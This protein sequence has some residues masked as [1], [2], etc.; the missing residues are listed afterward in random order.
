MRCSCTWWRACCPDADIV[1]LDTGY[2]FAETQWFAERLRERYH[3]NLR[4][5]RPRDD[6]LADQWQT[7]TDG[8]CAARKVEP[9]QRAL[10]GKSA[11]VTGLRRADSPSRAT[12]PVVHHDLLRGV[13]KVNPIATWSDAEVEHYAAM[14]LLPEHPLAGARLPRRSAAGRARAPVSEGDDARAGRWAG[15]AKTECG[16]HVDVAAAS[17]ERRGRQARER[18]PARPPG[19]RARR[20]TPTRSSTTDRAA[21]VPRHLPAGRPRRP[22]RAGVEEAAPRLLVHGARRRAGRADQRRAVAGPRPAGRARRRH[23]APDHPSGRAVPHGPQGRAARAGERHQPQ[24]AHHAGGVR[25]RRPQ[26][27]GLPVARRAPGGGRARCWPRWWPASVRR[28]R[29]TG[30]CGSTASAPCPPSRR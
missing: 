28:R 18:P 4:I 7:D 30:S 5:V 13:V 23:A 17:R 11:W 25:R 12:T 29:R 2:L 9:L 3:L 27:H 8:C 21:Q 26:R 15:S 22:P 16:L 24:P 1:L 14:E 10:A 20:P 19:H 6:V